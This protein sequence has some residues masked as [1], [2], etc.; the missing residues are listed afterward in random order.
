M[1]KT[2]ELLE[3]LTS[4]QCYK[5]ICQFSHV[6]G[7]YDKRNH[8]HHIRPKSLYPD[9]REAKDNLVY[10]DPLLHAVAHYYLK[11]H[12]RISDEVAY[13][14]M[15]DTPVGV[16]DFIRKNDPYRLERNLDEVVGQFEKEILPKMIECLVEDRPQDEFTDQLF[17]YL[18]YFDAGIDKGDDLDPSTI[19]KELKDLGF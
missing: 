13:E 18:D 8:C 5:I 1:K 12:Y 17:H 9:L 6:Y 19:V 3:E 14:K 15:M 4:L 7:V 10:M 2:E 11:D 16:L